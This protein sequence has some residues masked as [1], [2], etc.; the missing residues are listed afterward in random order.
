MLEV[1]HTNRGHDLLEPAII[2]PFLLFFFLVSPLLEKE[3]Q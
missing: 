2:F 1:I 3:T